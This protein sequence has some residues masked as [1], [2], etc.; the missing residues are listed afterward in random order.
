M[1]DNEKIHAI[2]EILIEEAE[3][4]ID[5]W[6]LDYDIL[7]EKYIKKAFYL[8]ETKTKEELIEEAKTYYRV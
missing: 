8:N 5:A 1:I 7:L 6:N 4:S 2:V 3:K